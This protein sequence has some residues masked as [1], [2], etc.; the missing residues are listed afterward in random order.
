MGSILASAGSGLYDPQVKNLKL[1]RVIKQSDARSLQRHR[2]MKSGHAQGN[3][4]EGPLSRC[5]S[6]NRWSR[7]DNERPEIHI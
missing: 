7:Y 5:H 2:E 4:D 3:L 1:R 6:Q